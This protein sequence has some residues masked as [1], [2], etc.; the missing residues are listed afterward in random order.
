[1]NSIRVFSPASVSNVCCGFDVLGFSI[2]GFGDEIFTG[3]IE[4]LLELSLPLSS[5]LLVLRLNKLDCA[6]LKLGFELNSDNSVSI[7]SRSAKPISGDFDA[8]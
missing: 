4:I 5:T 7:V 8:F 1:M 6:S 3:S 2:H